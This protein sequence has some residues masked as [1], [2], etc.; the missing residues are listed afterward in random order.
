MPDTQGRKA[1][2]AAFAVALFVAAPAFA[3]QLP[4]PDENALKLDQ[5]IQALKAEVVEF[6]AAAQAVE[7]AVRY[8]DYS[9]VSAYLGVRINGLL[10][11][12]SSVAIDDQPP[13]TYSYDERDARALLSEGNLQRILRTNVE[14]GPHRIRVSV[15]GR[16]ADADADDPP[17]TDTYEAIFDKG[18]GEA[19][20]EFVISR[21]SRLAKPRLSMKQWR[22]TR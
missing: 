20:L 21:P 22:A 9:R 6:A 17:V 10:L 11:T 13:E 19:E 8:P 2:G 16:I 1:P 12:E 14:P 4:P 5:T 3:A 18:V 7:D 15:T